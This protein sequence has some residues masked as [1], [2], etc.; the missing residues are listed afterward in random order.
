MDGAGNSRAGR[1]VA[2]MLVVTRARGSIACRVVVSMPIPMDDFAE[3]RH[4]GDRG[5]HIL[6][7]GLA[8]EFRNAHVDSRNHL[9]DPAGHGKARFGIGPVEKFRYCPA[10]R[11]LHDRGQHPRHRL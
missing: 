1:Q 2:D 5:R 10:A 8:R 11:H 3:H 6:E 7:E 4:S 9:A